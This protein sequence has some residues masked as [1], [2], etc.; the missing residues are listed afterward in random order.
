MNWFDRGIERIVVKVIAALILMA[1]VGIYSLFDDGGSSYGY[2][3]G[4]SIWLFV[5]LGLIAVCAFLGW[6]LRHRLVDMIKDFEV[7]RKAPPKD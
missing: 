7:W 6:F 2:H 5:V 4:P 1:A 3:H